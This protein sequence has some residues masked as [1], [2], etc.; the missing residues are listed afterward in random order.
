LT[1]EYAWKGVG[2]DLF[3]EKR[4]GK[5]GVAAVTPTDWAVS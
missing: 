5:W 2:Y 1:P 4:N 3:L